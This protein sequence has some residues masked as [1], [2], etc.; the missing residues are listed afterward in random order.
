[1]IKPFTS[2]VFTF[3]CLNLTAQVVQKAEEISPLLPGESLPNANLTNVSGN[4]V[5]VKELMAKKR[6]VL[7]FYRGGW[8]PFCN[9]QLAGLAKIEKEI[10]QA[11]FQLI[12]ISP[13]EHRNLNNTAGKNNANYTLL[14]DYGAKF[15]QQIGIGFAAP[16]SLKGYVISKGQL[17]DAPEVLPVPTVLVVDEKGKILFEYI[18]PN[19]KER[20]N[21][22]MLLAVLKTLVP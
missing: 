9:L 3:L 19:Y 14:S 6:S 1:M 17:G 20:L 5:D 12:A 4:P 11:G 21:E 22:N 8:C 13:D 10:S 2:L 7:V 15:I 18:N 16:P